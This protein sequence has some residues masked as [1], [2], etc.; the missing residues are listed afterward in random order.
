MHSFSL[1]RRPPSGT[2]SRSHHHRLEEGKSRR[3]EVVVSEAPG[4][5]RQVL[6]QDLSYGPGVGW[7]VQK[8]IALDAA[9]VDAL[10]RSLC[11]VRQPGKACPLASAEP[12]AAGRGESAEAVIVRLR[13]LAG[14]R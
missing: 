12:D 1:R 9:H 2:S 7:Y 10:L 3:I 8:T 13:D 11:C 6:L 4:G 5:Q 14:E